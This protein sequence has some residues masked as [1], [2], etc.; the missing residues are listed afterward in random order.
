VR[1]DSTA[2][3]FWYHRAHDLGAT[4]AEVLLKALETESK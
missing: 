1:G 2:A 4:D 3:S